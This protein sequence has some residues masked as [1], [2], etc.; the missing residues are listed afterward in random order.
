MFLVS[1]LNRLLN[2]AIRAESRLQRITTPHEPTRSRT[3]LTMAMANVS[4]KSQG[5]K[6]PSLLPKKI[7]LKNW[8]ASLSLLTSKSLSMRMTSVKP[9]KSQCA[10]EE[11]RMTSQFTWHWP[12]FNTANF[13]FYGELE[14]L[15][16]I[17]N[18]HFLSVSCFS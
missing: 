12:Y 11:P 10:N 14:F 15:N 1:R 2:N 8:S 13:C 9:G 4:S 17:K 5:I 6:G 7:K 16:E 3:W 18:S